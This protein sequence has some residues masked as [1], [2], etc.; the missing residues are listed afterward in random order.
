MA[1]TFVPQ[2]PM[3]LAS[4]D[5]ASKTTHNTGSYKL[6]TDPESNPS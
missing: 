3:K 1:A 2:V 6:E 4:V 5:R